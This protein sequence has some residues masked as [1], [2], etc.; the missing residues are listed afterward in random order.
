MT[1]LRR[2]TALAAAPLLAAL[3]P[4]ALGAPATAQDSPSRSLIVERPEADVLLLVFR[5]H[6]TI[7][8]ET[9]PVYQE[10]GRILI[11]LGAVCQ[12]L[13]LGITVDVARG[14]AGGF[15]LSERRTF[16]LDVLSRKVLVEGK[17][18]R[19]DP[20]G[21][22]VH[23]D[24]LY[25]DAALLSEWLPLHLQV[26]LYGAVITV[27]PAEK[28]PLELR[29]ERAARL[30]TSRA[31]QA[32]PAASHSRIDLPYRFF[33][34]PF[35]DQT[36]R[37]ARLP[38]PDGKSQ[39][40]LLYTTY[41]TGDL[42][43]LEANA[44]VSGTAHEVAD[45]RFSLGR[46]DPE[47]ALLGFLHA[48]ELTIGDTFHPGLD[49]IALPRSGP[50]L[51]LSNYPLQRP[52]QFDR[53]SF[54]GD[55][56]PGWEVELYRGDELL[57]Y[58]QS[59][60]DGL[61]EL[62]D[63][64][65]L[66]GLNLFRLEFYGPQG[67]RRR[68]THRYNVGE[69]LTPKGQLYYRLAG[70]D[71]GYR[72]LGTAPLDA[73]PR[74][75]LEVS[76]GLSSH[77][78]ASANL[79]SVD[80]LDG[81]HTYGEAGLRA[82]WGW[83]FANAN[84]AADRSGGSAWQGT[85]QSR[86]GSFGLLVQHAEARHFA[87]EALTSGTDPLRSRTVLRLD[88]AFPETFLP[89]IPI[90]LDLRQDRLENGGRLRQISGRL[91]AFRR[92]LSLSNQLS[93]NL[94]S[95]GVT[96]LSSNAFGQLL[97]SKYLQSFSL[98]GELTYDL[99]PAREVTGALLTVD[100]RLGGGLLVSAGANRV[101]RSDQTRFLA[102]VSKLEGPIGFT[103]TADYSSPGGFGLAVL[104]AESFG[105][106]PRTGQWHGA[107]RAFAGFGALSGRACRDSDGN[108]VMD[109][110]E[111]PIPGAGFLL[112]GGGNLAR[113]NDAGVAFLP[114][115]N[116]Y[117]DLDLALAAST[118][119]DPYWKPAVDGVRVTPRPGKVAVV[120]FPVE[121]AGEV[122]G[123]LFLR[124]NG[125]SR[126]AGGVE[127][128]LVDRQGAVVQRVKSAFDGFYDLTEVRSGR[129]TLRVAGEQVG[130]LRLAAAPARTVEIGASGTVVENLDFFLTGEPSGDAA[131]DRR[132]VAEPRPVEVLP[133]S[134]PEAV[135]AAPPRPPSAPSRPPVPAPEG[136]RIPVFAAR[137]WTGA[138]PIYAVQLAAYR[139]RAKAESDARSLAGRLRC[140]TH[141]FAVD[142]GAKGTWYRVLAGELPT[143]EE[144]LAFQR[145][146]AAMGLREV[147]LAYRVEVRR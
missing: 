113:T 65:L 22:E 139:E 92:G 80:L 109:A 5:L 73:R 12:L 102:G 20:A 67:Q 87:S 112:N 127:L 147:G 132:A 93:W 103:V 128:E 31:A 10:Q 120:D 50:G 44:F 58:A 114:N 28:L 23:Q 19:F 1:R 118:L 25:V 21:I 9:L 105:R 37:F 77:L 61:Y 100:R 89:R 68:E 106:D 45:S 142:L 48:R 145:E 121:V 137:E 79:A 90:L 126:A 140:K 26:D 69:T 82:F 107:A 43:F 85:L 35:V 124:R 71:P 7:L 88:T 75:T 116:P 134:A 64:P 38:L 98:R 8:A 36:L 56:P 125:Q 52:T 143:A 123:T 76:A 51:L 29:L 83:L 18:K 49:L 74:S 47:G 104:L 141:V 30:A 130:P 110:G 146:L 27:E 32:P 72:L 97:I 108:G 24:D 99:R 63:V 46:K 86:L 133:A 91:S 41:A 33:D 14:L 131:G 17:A 122:T 138:S 62:L 84:V 136:R 40:D 78:S 42:A 60:P 135:V 59:R 3:L 11:P 4:I 54:R 117:Q 16:S 115:L 34:G 81:R 6:R 144:A 94:S 70:N 13:D 96:P 111:K 101:F 55:L 39:N 15:F 119:E 57:A 129:Y 53:Q 2:R 66:F 95:G